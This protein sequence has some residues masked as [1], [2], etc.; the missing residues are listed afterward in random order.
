MRK[1]AA[2]LAIPF[3]AGSIML[4]GTAA[5]ATTLHHP[6][7]VRQCTNPWLP[8]APQNQGTERWGGTCHP[9]VAV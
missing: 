7:I 2:L 9:W 1:L 3:V 5:H 4:T 6:V 8:F